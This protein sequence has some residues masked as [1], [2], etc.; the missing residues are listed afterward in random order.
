MQLFVV[1]DVTDELLLL[2]CP[3]LSDKKRIDLVE[4][5]EGN[6][7]WSVVLRSSELEL[8]VVVCPP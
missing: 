1:E 3:L 5:N 2:S 7:P 8:L 4:N 6:L